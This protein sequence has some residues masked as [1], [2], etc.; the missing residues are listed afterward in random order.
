MD[1][2]MHRPA[3][4]FLVLFGAPVLAAPIDREVA[5]VDVQ[6]TTAQLVRT[7][8]IDGG[9]KLRLVVTPK[10]KKAQTVTIY[11]G[12]GDDDGAGAAE[13]KGATSEALELPDGSRGVR[14]DFEFQVPGDKKHHQTDTYLVALDDTPHT[15]LEVTTHKER[16]ASRVCREV[17][18]TALVLDKSGKLFVRPTLLL[19]SALNDED[20]PVDPECVGKHP[21]RV[22][23]Y[24]YDGE[25]FL[26]IDPAPRAPK[27]TQPAAE[28]EDDE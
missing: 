28:E 8:L 21:G 7:H 14:I 13:W 6:G 23:T 17:E 11:E 4:A 3:L 20:S 18:Q 25:T 16:N 10:K 15:L 9:M 24:K 26:Q 22:I 19:D 12:G 2:A 27:K 5:K 1:D